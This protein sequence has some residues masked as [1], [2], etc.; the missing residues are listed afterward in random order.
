M[1]ACQL[2]SYVQYSLP[3]LPACVCAHTHAGVVAIRRLYTVCVLERQTCVVVHMLFAH[4]VGAGLQWFVLGDSLF[5]SCMCLSAQ[6][7]AEGWE[8]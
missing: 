4:A 1:I 6:D 5:L 8:G 7:A 2:E 3:V